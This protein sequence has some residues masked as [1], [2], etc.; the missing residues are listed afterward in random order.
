MWSRWKSQLNSKANDLTVTFRQYGSHALANVLDDLRE[1]DVKV[2][3]L[4]PRHCIRTLN[5]CIY[6]STV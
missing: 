3:E 2:P 5:E 6:T 4:D 1:S